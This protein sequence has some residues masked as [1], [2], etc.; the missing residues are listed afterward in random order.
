M[1]VMYMML[2]KHIWQMCLLKLT[3][4]YTI[5]EQWSS[6]HTVATNHKLYQDIS[7]KYQAKFST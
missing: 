5:L 7:I 6:T 1:A 3:V 2:L 4:Y